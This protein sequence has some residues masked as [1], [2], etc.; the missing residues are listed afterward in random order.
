LGALAALTVAGAGISAVSA[1]PAAVRAPG[2]PAPGVVAFDSCRDFAGHMRRRALE[3]IGPYGLQGSASPEALRAAAPVGGDAAASAPSS[4]GPQ[5]GV[6]FSGTNLQ[7]AGVDEPDLVKT[8]GRTIFSVTGGRLSAVDVRGPKPRALAGL[9]LDRL[10]PSGLLLVGD[11]LLVLGDGGSGFVGD[12]ATTR[13]AA[14]AIAPAWKPSTVLVQLDVSDP[15]HPRVV[16]RMRIDG[17]LVS[18]RRTGDT[19]RVVLSS[20]PAY[21]PLTQ[22]AGE[23]L[24]VARVA[25]RANRR[26]VTR[27]NAS[28]WLPRLTIRDVAAKRTTR[29]VAVGCR[30]VSRPTSFSGLGMIDVL[31]L[32][33]TDELALVDSDAIMTDADLVYASPTALYV[34]TPRWAA[35]EAATAASPPRGSTL[36]HKLDI[37][38]PGRTVYR[39]SG[40]VRGYLLNQFSLSEHEGVLR[41]AST[42]VPE[43]WSPPGAA[44]PS[45]S[46]VTTLAESAGRLAAVGQVGGIGKGERIFAV[47]FLGARGYVVTFRQTDPLYALDL[48]DPAHPRVRGEL[49]I[50]GFSSYLHPIDDDTLIGVGQAADADGR[51]QGTQVSLFDVSDLD[52]PR[53]IAQRTLDAAWSEAESDHHAFL[54]WPATAALVLPAQTYGPDGTNRF[55][56]AVGLTV[57]R[58]TGIT[59]IARVAHPDQNGETWSP[60]RRSLVIGDALYTISDTGIMES[61]LTTLEPRGWIPFR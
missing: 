23:G 5:S 54:Y 42:E 52:A 45:E 3:M 2:K 39:A 38:D 59:P 55:L 18:A 1:A 4:P 41:T 58:Q 48:S 14:G 56:G 11:R 43:W 53:R 34:A 15:A 25:T 20:G 9:D 32:D 16:T 24:G 28:A 36:V 17:R 26:L 22:P 12:I 19:V 47:R 29:R 33:A 46:F 27:S 51:T 35:P 37:S 61:A 6:D 31:T 30:A 10:S 13:V 49:K 44:A 40:V 50:P 60:V 57:A 8:D 7:E 21:L